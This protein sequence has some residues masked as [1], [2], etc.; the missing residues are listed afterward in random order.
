MSLKDK[1]WHILA[2]EDPENRISRNFNQFILTLIVLNVIAVIVESVPSIHRGNH[3]ALRS[4]E[5]FSVAIFLVEYLLR[6]WSCTSC[7]TYAHPLWGRI[8][9]IFSFLAIVD[10]VAILPSLLLFLGIDFRAIRA[11]RL[12]RLFLLAKTSRYT[13]SVGLLGK[14]FI[15]KREELII[16][17]SLLAFLLIMASTLMF[18]VENRA[19]PDAFSSIP[20]TMWWAVATLTTVGYGDIAPITG[21]GK[22]LGS[23]VAIIGI[24]L[25]ALPTSILGSGF[26]EELQRAKDVDVKCPDCG[27]EFTHHVD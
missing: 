20:A 14:V 25:F 7:P 5:F 12:M 18:Y 27:K 11:L 10:L 26:L 15:Q 16:S 17:L 13:R 22:L 3:L 23:V 6:L 21:L 19:Q 2:N 8:K 9:F 1:T 4:F 24:G